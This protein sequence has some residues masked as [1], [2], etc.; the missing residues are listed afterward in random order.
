MGLLKTYNIN[1]KQAGMAIERWWANPYY[2]SLCSQADIKSAEQLEMVIDSGDL[3]RVPVILDTDAKILP[4]RT[5]TGTLSGG[6]SIQLTE[7]LIEA[8]PSK[9]PLFMDFSSGENPDC[10]IRTEEEIA[11]EK[12]N[13]LE[14]F[15]IGTGTKHFDGLLSLFPSRSSLER[16]ARADYNK[17]QKAGILAGA[18]RSVM[19]RRQTESGLDAAESISDLSHDGLLK[20]NLPLTILNRTILRRWKGGAVQIRPNY[21]LITKILREY[22]KNGRT[23]LIGTSPIFAYLYMNAVADCTFDFQGRIRLHG[24]GGGYR[25]WKGPLRLPNAIDQTQYASMMKGIFGVY[26]SETYGY[27]GQTHTLALK[28][29]SEREWYDAEKQVEK[30]GAYEAYPKRDVC[31][32]A[33]VYA[34]NPLKGEVVG[35][36]PGLIRSINFEGSHAQFDGAMQVQ[37][38]CYVDGT[39]EYGIPTVIFGISGTGDKPGC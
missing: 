27:T 26:P 10:V 30:K 33:I 11:I 25:G 2:R 34:F 21:E 3:A 35:K 39:D 24:G 4:A 22:E 32:S 29:N 8:I 28:W 12:A 19:P 37:D 5:A 7:G 17:A 20:F 36:G 6:K 18:Q 1:V 15:I 38:R 31:G 13:Y 9:L 14:S 23:A 16:G